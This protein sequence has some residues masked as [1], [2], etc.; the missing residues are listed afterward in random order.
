MSVD[1]NDYVATSENI[2]AAHMNSRGVTSLAG[3][4]FAGVTKY[5]GQIV[6]CNSTASTFIVGHYY[7]YDGSNFQVIDTLRA[8]GA[9][10]AAHNTYVGM[11]VFCN[12]S[13]SGFTV[14]LVYVRDTA[15]AA[16]IEQFNISIY[17]LG[18]EYVIGDGG[19]V[20]SHD[21]EVTETASSLTLQKTITLDELIPNTV[22][23]RI[24]F[25]LKTD[26][27]G[28]CNGRIF[29]NG[30]TVG[31][32]RA[33]SDGT[34]ETYSE[35]LSFT[36]GDDLELYIDKI[37]GGDGFARNFRIYGTIDTT[38]ATLIKAF[39]NGDAADDPL[40]GTNS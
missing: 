39:N 18:N 25:D 8:T 1:N 9:E 34:Y 30:G 37:G 11:K 24:K 31:T 33:K 28:T 16:W 14:D 20:H 40:D 26:G 19:P 2:I 22:I 7:R 6:Y 36:K 10:I 29:K 15:D 27:S 5:T 12:S 32:N 35:D 38:P 23:L 17:D 21:G 13:G 4:E 3:G